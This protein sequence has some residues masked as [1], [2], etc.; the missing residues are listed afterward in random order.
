MLSWRDKSIL[1]LMRS[2]TLYQQVK[3]EMW[4]LSIVLQV[5]C[6]GSRAWRSGSTGEGGGGGGRL[7][8]QPCRWAAKAGMEFVGAGGLMEEREALSSVPS[9]TRGSGSLRKR[10]GGNRS[11]LLG[12]VRPR[13][14]N[15][16]CDTKS[17][18]CAPG[19][20][21]SDSAG[22]STDTCVAHSTGFLWCRYLI[23]LD[24]TPPPT[25]LR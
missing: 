19:G 12:V 13:D 18:R 3:R 11:F 24:T 23:P 7:S 2:R 22:Q 5:S 9:V 4:N 8:D 16:T 6:L 15:L 25:T 21:A 20:L 1:G 10:D 17:A 14:G